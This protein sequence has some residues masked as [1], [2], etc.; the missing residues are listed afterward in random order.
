[1][2]NVTCL[3]IITIWCICLQEVMY[4]YLILFVRD[5]SPRCGGRGR[6][7]V[8]HGGRCCWYYWRQALVYIIRGRCR[9]RYQPMWASR[10]RCVR[11]RHCCGTL[12]FSVLGVTREA[13]VCAWS[14]CPQSEDKMEVCVLYPNQVRVGQ[15]RRSTMAI[16]WR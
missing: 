16:D 9:C 4:C 11:P 8:L 6:H 1:M 5:T 12:R 7:F 2:S 15:I 13:R 10:F 14:T 3:V